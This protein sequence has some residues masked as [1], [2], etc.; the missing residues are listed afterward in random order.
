MT[1]K[2]KLY[3]DLVEKAPQ[4]SNNLGIPSNLI[5]ALY[6]FTS[7]FSHISN[8]LSMQSAIL[9]TIVP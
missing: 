4:L 7:L 8:I 1:I 9:K 6:L 2:V 5:R 3:G